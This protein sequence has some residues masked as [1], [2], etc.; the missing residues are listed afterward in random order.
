MGIHKLQ[1]KREKISKE[2]AD[3]IKATK[4]QIQQGE[5]LREK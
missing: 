5:K 2:N 1:N 3:R 4:D